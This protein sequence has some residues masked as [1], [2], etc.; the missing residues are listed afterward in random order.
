MS[1]INRRSFFKTAAAGALL[2]GAPARA[3][4]PALPPP[5]A[6]R[7]ARIA[8]VCQ[9]GLMRKT[10]DES[11]KLML[12]VADQALA[13]KP[14]LLCLPE[15]FATAAMP[16]NAHEKVEALNGST[17]SAAAE[18]ARK[19][20]CNIVCPSYT[21]RDGHV[22][23][24]ATILD[25]DGKIVGAYDKACPVTTSYDYTLLENG[26][27][28]GTPDI[29]VFDLDIGRIGVQICYDI[30]F[31]ENWDL[32]RKKG[33]QL[34]LWPS[35]YDGGT[36]LWTYAYLHHYYVMSSVRSG[37]SRIIDP[38]GAIL[39]ETK[40]ET[41]FIIRD[42]NLDNIVSHLD[43]NTSIPDK[44]KTKYGDRVDVRRANPGS[45]HFI[46][47]PID[48]A[49]T[50]AALQKEF[51][52]ESSFQ[53]H[54]RHRAIYAGARTGKNLPAQTALHGNRPQWGKF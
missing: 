9:L 11:L 50:V 46:V 39:A 48:P 20:R 3:E 6:G 37:Q 34:V 49:I 24:T 32:L 5:P 10:I 36:P 51:G 19:H 8:S 47:E 26:V 2:A 21:L 52:F 18:R 15:N 4:T 1:Q 44:I 14:D 53:Y 29:P 42:I 16:G 38:L 45:S 22:F 35:A 28:P 17:I 31:P 23:N 27:T 30:G 43:W 7:R 33:A 41:R 54:D 25:R 40:D 13:E 12:E